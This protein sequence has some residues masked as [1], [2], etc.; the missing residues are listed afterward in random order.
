[1][2]KFTKQI[3]LLLIIIASLISVASISIAETLLSKGDTGEEVKKLQAALAELGY[4]ITD[5]EG[6]FG[7]ST[8]NAVF[9]FQDEHGLKATGIL[10]A[11][12]YH[13]LFEPDE[14]Q[15][16]EVSESEEEVVYSR[17]EP[18]PG[19]IATAKSWLWLLGYDCG[20]TN[21]DADELFNEQILKFQKDYS[22]NETGVCDSATRDMIEKQ[23]NIPKLFPVLLE[24][25]NGALL[26]GLINTDGD[27]VVPAEYER[28]SFE[29]GIYDMS[30][31]S[32]SVRDFYYPN[33][34][35]MFIEY[36]TNGGFTNGFCV[37]EDKGAGLINTACNLVVPMDW[38]VMTLY[39]NYSDS[40]WEVKQNG[41]YGAIDPMGNLIIEC[42][43]DKAP[44]ALGEGWYDFRGDK[45]VNIYDPSLIIDYNDNWE[46]MAVGRFSDGI[47][48][49]RYSNKQEYMYDTKG[50]IA[51]QIV[52]DDIGSYFRCGRDYVKQGN[53]YGFIDTSG[54]VVIDIQ[55]EDVSQF[56]EDYASVRLPGSDRFT[57]IDQFGNNPMPDVWS[58][59]HIYFSNGLARIIQEGK[60]GFVDTEGKIIIPCEWDT[61]EVETANWGSE[62]SAF[63]SLFQFEGDLVL[64]AKNDKMY[65][66]NKSG[67][68]VAYAGPASILPTEPKKEPEK[69]PNINTN[70]S[71]SECERIAV[72]YLKDYL[73]NPDSLQIHST[74]A[75]RS[76][77]EYTF[78]IDYSAM[79]SFGGFTRSTYICVVDSTNG[80]VT[81]AFSN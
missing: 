22:L 12:T 61:C 66:I 18:F 54:N 50:E 73:K 10:D 71:Q 9:L 53:L 49:V 44:W 59:N 79:N 69:A 58:E 67:E 24:A 2:K 74:S 81:S 28:C 13:A 48:Y 11:E 38:G 37:V 33:G 27:L 4:T 40:S 31:S 21:G 5:P 23:V 62:Y 56:F 17:N 7:S 64:V 72:D 76:G 43:A 6:E 60:V 25:D 32:W 80:K 51:F 30:K 8:K 39:P 19:E 15:S 65:Y 78:I 16:T 26:F 70:K 3:I 42:I 68:I 45:F 34:S 77:D 14:E 35:K 47:L 1:M 75:T 57:V 63:S 20:N 55:Y 36:E 41:R 46:K 29:D 52:W